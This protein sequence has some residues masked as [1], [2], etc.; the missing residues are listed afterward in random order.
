MIYKLYNATGCN[1]HFWILCSF[2]YWLVVTNRTAIATQTCNEAT[3]ENNKKPNELKIHLL[4]LLL[5]FLLMSMSPFMTLLLLSTFTSLTSTSLHYM[6]L[7]D[8]TFTLLCQSHLRLWWELLFVWFICLLLSLL[9]L[10]FA[11]LHPVNTI[12]KNVD[13]SI[14]LA[15]ISLF[16]GTWYHCHPCCC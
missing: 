14:S 7:F 10:L 3:S 4:M 16:D 6:V 1:E 2:M 5:Q 13:V 11:S 9:V 8:N 15:P 12:I